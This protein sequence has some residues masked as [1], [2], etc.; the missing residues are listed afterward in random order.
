MLGFGIREWWA[1]KEAW[2]WLINIGVSIE[3][4]PCTI[5]GV[6]IISPYKRI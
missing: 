5:M 2:V 4:C 1:L 3:K 6:S